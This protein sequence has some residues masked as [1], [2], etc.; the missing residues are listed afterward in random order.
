MTLVLIF[1][2]A[3]GY[4]LNKLPFYVVLLSVTRFYRFFRLIL[5]ITYIKVIYMSLVEFFPY[6]KTIFFTLGLMFFF[7]YGLGNHIFGGHLNESQRHKLEDTKLP[8]DYIYNNFNDAQSGIIL[9]FELIVVNNWMVNAAV[10]VTVMNNN[11]FYRI[12][13]IIWYFFGVILAV[14]IVVA[15]IIDFLVN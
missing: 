6:I 14:N 4:G 5:K 15:F 9:L 12:F 3:F 1:V 11:H 10:H 13:F 7:F 8:G 2:Y